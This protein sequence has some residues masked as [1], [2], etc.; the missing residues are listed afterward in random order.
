MKIIIELEQ[1]DIYE[2]NQKIDC[3]ITDTEV[4]DYKWIEIGTEKYS[5]KT[6]DLQDLAKIL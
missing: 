2:K 4:P 1:D 6:K 3:I 5:V